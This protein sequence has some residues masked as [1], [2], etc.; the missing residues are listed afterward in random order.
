CS[1]VLVIL[2]LWWFVRLP[3]PI[4]RNVSVAGVQ[5]EFPTEHE[6][7]VALDKLIET[8]PEAKLIVLCEYAFDNPI[9]ESVKAWCKEHQRYLI[10]G[11]KD[12]TPQTNFYDT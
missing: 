3:Y 4:G 1:A 9:P 5:L 8:H 6:V 10:A 7:I 2:A 12:P 11:G